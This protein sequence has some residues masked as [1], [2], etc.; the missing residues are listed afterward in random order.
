M[1][2]LAPW[3]FTLLGYQAGFAKPLYLLGLL[4]AIAVGVLGLV[5]AFRRRAQVRALLSDRLAGALA[6]GVSAKALPTRPR[7]R[8]TCSTCPPRAWARSR[9]G[10]SISW[11]S[12]PVATVRPAAAWRT[13]SRRGATTRTTCARRST[14]C[15]G[16]MPWPTCARR[17]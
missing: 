2:E 5:A 7:I 16:A 17:P 1:T 15:R 11:M 3:R 13:A 14:P 9:N 12:S 8:P 4:L 10:R 6:P